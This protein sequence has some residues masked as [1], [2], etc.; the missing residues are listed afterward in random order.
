MKAI[1][2]YVPYG[3]DAFVFRARHKISGLERTFENSQPK[4]CLC[5][6]KSSCGQIRMISGQIPF[7]DYHFANDQKFNIQISVSY[8]HCHECLSS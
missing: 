6:I 3:T 5:L 7:E 2:L 4:C 8:K 1:A